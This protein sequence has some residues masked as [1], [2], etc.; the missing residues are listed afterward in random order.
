MFRAKGKGEQQ[1]FWIER[2]RLAQVQVSNFYQNVNEVL[3]GIK[4]A[5]QVHR[6]C[7]PAYCGDNQGRPGIDPVVYFKMLM[8]GFFENIG[9]ERGIAARCS[10]SLS[11][12]EFL[13]YELNESTPD[14][15][16]L[17][18][19]RQR[20][21]GEM[22]QAV[23]EL[24]LLSLERQGLLKGRNLGIDA[25]IIEANAALR[26]LENRNT[27]EAYWE[28]VKRLAEQAGVDGQDA[29]AVRRFDRKR[30]GRQTSNK[31]WVNP[32][33]RDAKVGRTKGGTTDMIYKCEHVVDLD[34]GVVLSAQVQPGDKQDSEALCEQILEAEAAI[35]RAKQIEPQIVVQSVTADKG[36]YATQALSQMQ[37][38]CLQTIISDPIQNRRL[39]ALACEERAAVEEAKRSVKSPA[40][41]DLLARRGMH[42]ERSFAHLL[43]CG[44]MRRTTLRGLHNLK[45]RY[46]VAAFSYNLSQLLRA[47]GFQGTAKQAIAGSKGSLRALI[48]FQTMFIDSIGSLT[49]LTASYCDLLP[50]NYTLTFC[51]Y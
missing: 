34:S 48:R 40:G 22:Y 29:A 1:E 24:M 13:S 2:K 31:E 7:R 35:H 11:I 5:E 47:I 16:S 4:F 8:V 46:W 33:D 38:L 27:Q 37:E 10:D 28:Y 20:L 9:S 12:R 21:S 18:V 36:Y 6:I 25:S 26:S 51:S 14:H 41:K 32:H 23:F 19:I 50:H 49:S 30:E 42:I 43:D 44:G 15:S 39:E 17:S 3:E 45:K